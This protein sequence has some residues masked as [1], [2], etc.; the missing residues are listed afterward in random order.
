ML[1]PEL[2]VGA[3]LGLLAYWLTPRIVYRSKR[4]ELQAERD[5]VIEHPEPKARKRQLPAP[6]GSLTF[7]AQIRARDR[8]THK[9]VADQRAALAGVAGERAGDFVPAPECPP[10]LAHS[11]RSTLRLLRDYLASFT[12]NARKR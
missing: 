12:T 7:G 6:S 10:I 3:A 8:G 2:F 1:Y 9:V 11:T 5:D 4:A